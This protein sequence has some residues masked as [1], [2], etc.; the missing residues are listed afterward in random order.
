MTRSK[1]EST[2]TI[3]LVNLVMKRDSVFMA[4]SSGRGLSKPHSDGRTPFLLTLFGCGSAALGEGR[5]VRVGW[6][7]ADP[8]DRR[9]S[10]EGQARVGT[11]R[12]AVR[13]RVG[14]AGLTV[15]IVDWFTVLGAKL[16]SLL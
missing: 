14:V 10:R 7:A 9:R 6:T 16:G 15:N 11:A 3:K 12:G 8:G 13:F 1:Q 2:A 4:F 5:G